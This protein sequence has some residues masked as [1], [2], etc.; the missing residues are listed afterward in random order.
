VACGGGGGGGN[1]GAGSTEVTITVQ[2][3]ARATVYDGQQ[4]PNVNAG[5]RV[6]GDLSPFRTQPLVLVLEVSDPTIFETTPALSIAS[7]GVSGFAQLT[8]KF[9]RGGPG[10]HSGVLT[11]HACLG[12]DCKTE[13]RV[14][15]ATIPYQI[16][17][18]QTVAVDRPVVDLSTPFGSLPVETAVAVTLPEGAMSWRA[19]PL[20]TGAFGKSI[21]RKSPDGSNSLLVT[22]DGL[23]PSGYAQTENWVITAVAPD[24]QELKTL[25]SVNLATLASTVDHAFVRQPHFELT[26]GVEAHTQ[27]LDTSLLFQTAQSDRVRLL[28][29]D[30][31]TWPAAATDPTLRQS[32]LFAFTRDGEFPRQVL[33][34]YEIRTS[35]QNCFNGSCLPAGDYAATMHFEYTPAQGSPVVLDMPVTMSLTPAP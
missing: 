34:T 20:L 14:N 7:D 4:I 35:V 11:V 18:L 25:L 2:G 27:E 28:G 1:G 29:I 21:V 6:T 5:F 22:Q 33:N 32:W 15:G 9:W 16:T 17:I 30:Y 19:E 12:V 8:G 26:Q 31:T 23:A 13:L 24:Q 3:S 10:I